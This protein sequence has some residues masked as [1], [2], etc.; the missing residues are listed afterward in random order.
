MDGG[1]VT[2]RMWGGV[3]GRVWGRGRGRGV[4][5]MRGNGKMG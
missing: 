1:V 5:S 4:S 3:W 2:M